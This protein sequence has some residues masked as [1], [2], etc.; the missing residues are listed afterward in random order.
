ME[1]L[2]KKAV[3][4]WQEMEGKNKV[5]WVVDTACESRGVAS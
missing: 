1:R 3:G 4:G 5:V 2:M